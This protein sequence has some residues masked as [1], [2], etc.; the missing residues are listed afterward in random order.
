MNHW[1]THTNFVSEQTNSLFLILTNSLSPSSPFLSLSSLP[2]FFFLSFSLSNSEKVLFKRRVRKENKAR[3]IPGL[4]RGVIKQIP[5]KAKIF[6]LLCIFNK[7]QQ[8]RGRVVERFHWVENRQ[9]F[10]FLNC[11]LIEN[12][13]VFQFCPFFIVLGVRG[14]MLDYGACTLSCACHNDKVV[15]HILS[16]GALE[17]WHCYGIGN[18]NGNATW[19]AGDGTCNF[20]LGL[21]FSNFSLHKFFSM[22]LTHPIAVPFLTQQLS[23]G[24]EP[25]IFSWWWGNWI[26]G[27]CFLTLGSFWNCDWFLFLGGI[28]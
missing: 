13:L 7:T 1:G 2:P 17:M 3:K 20:M 26:S 24:E 12:L 19:I 23:T 27:L 21:K 11:F 25:I 28:C 16:W 14:H 8:G 9:H 22:I 15:V 6:L 5:G 4:G 18:F 10:W